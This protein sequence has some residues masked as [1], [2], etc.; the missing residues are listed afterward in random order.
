MLP[1]LAHHDHTALEVFCYCDVRHRDDLTGQLR[2]CA[3]VWRNIVGLSDPQVADMVRQDRIDI[4]VDLAG[5]T[6]DNRPLV[7]A[8]K[9]APVQVAWLGYPG[10][11]GLSTMDYRLT[12]MVS[13]P[14]GLT[15][16]FYTEQLIRLPDTYWCY[17]PADGTPEV[18]ALPA[19]SAGHV[20]FGC[21]NNFA[22]VTSVTLLA[23]RQ[24]LRQMPNARLLLHCKEGSHRHKVRELLT[25]EGI[26]P[27]RLDFTGL[28]PW[29][30][31][32]QLYHRIDIALDTFPHGGGTT[33]CDA[34][35][36]GVPVVT[37]AGQTAVSHAD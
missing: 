17:Q 34:L 24:L 1:V 32:F 16:A 31:Y 3:D 20:T 36:M 2:P 5:H 22:K 19:L 33:T 10:T 27:A 13:N 7:F 8:R 25:Q 21:L 15:D 12:D 14:P 28:L 29:P 37:L 4:L 26:D 23:W 9:P 35:W 18:N 30:Q 11:T 6:A